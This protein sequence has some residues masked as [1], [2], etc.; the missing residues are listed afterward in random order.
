L[1]KKKKNL[2]AKRFLKNFQVASLGAL[3][4]YEEILLSCN[5]VVSQMYVVWMEI[6]FHFLK[7]TSIE[8]ACREL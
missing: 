6:H 8:V 2:N 7:A 5:E 1:E 4:M 3:G